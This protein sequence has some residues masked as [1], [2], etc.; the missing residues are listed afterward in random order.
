MFIIINIWWWCKNEPFIQRNPRPYIIHYLVFSP[1]SS[2]NSK[3]PDSEYIRKKK[4]TVKLV[5]TGQT[6]NTLFTETFHSGKT[7]ELSKKINTSNK[8]MNIQYTKKKEQTY[9]L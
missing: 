4:K 9:I 8:I 1:R 3:F 5:G 6:Q 2:N 7:L